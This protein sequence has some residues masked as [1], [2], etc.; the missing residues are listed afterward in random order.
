MYCYFI[1]QEAARSKLIA[2]A[3]RDLKAK[4]KKEAKAQWERD[5]PLRN[6]LKNQQNEEKRIAKDTAD[7]E[8]SSKTAAKKAADSEKAANQVKVK[9][10]RLADRAIKQALID[11]R[12][13]QAELKKIS[14]R[15][16]NASKKKQRT[17][18][19]C[20]MCNRD[21]SELSKCCHPKCKSYFCNNCHAS[22]VQHERICVH[23]TT[24]S[25]WNNDTEFNFGAVV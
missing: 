19:K 20:S 16:V 10:A 2:K 21:N 15:E 24:A 14:D 11:D 5:E 9:N 12:K 13:A 4:E 1:L 18:T 25:N 3:D 22:L 23:L 6:L 7:K 17:T 8:R